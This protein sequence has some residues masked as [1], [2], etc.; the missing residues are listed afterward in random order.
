MQAPVGRKVR[1]TF[2]DFSFRPRMDKPGSR[3]NG[4]CAY[5]SVEMRTGNMDEGEL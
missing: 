1:V 4:L 5:E 2:D 3:Y